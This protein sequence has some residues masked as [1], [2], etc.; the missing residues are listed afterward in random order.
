MHSTVYYSHT[1]SN[2]P[3]FFLFRAGS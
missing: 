2:Q 1:I 3:F